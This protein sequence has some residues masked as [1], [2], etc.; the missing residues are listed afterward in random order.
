MPEVKFW[1]IIASVAKKKR[2]I[3]QWE[4]ALD[5]KLAKMKLEALV[6]FQ[7][8]VNE[9]LARSYHEDMLCAFAILEGSTEKKAFEGFRCWLIMHGKEV[10]NRAV[11]DPDTI[12]EILIHGVEDHYFPKL[13]DAAIAA[14]RKLS[15]NDEVAAFTQSKGAVE[16]E[17]IINWKMHDDDSMKAICPGLWEHIHG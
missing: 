6:A 8:R 13:K 1:K 9:L 12:V 15:G 5:N 11:Q 3:K 17:L 2:S 4:E 10:F 14:F 16:P 7:L